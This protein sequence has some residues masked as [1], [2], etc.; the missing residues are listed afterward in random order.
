MTD[1]VFYEA[2]GG[3]VTLTLNRPEKRNPISEH[4]VVEGG[5]AA[6]LGVRRRSPW[7]DLD[8]W[9]AGLLSE[10]GTERAIVDGAADLQQQVGAA[11]RPAHL[12]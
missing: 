3:I 8:H 7:S 4:D 1:A 10:A 5:T 12:L 11:S 2:D 9:L 6:R